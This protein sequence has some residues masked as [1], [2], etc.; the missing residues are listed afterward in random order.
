MKGK[1]P[2][3]LV[4]GLA[5]GSVVLISG[6]VFSGLAMSQDQML[7]RGSTNLPSAVFGRDLIAPSA[8]AP[9][10]SQ[11]ISEVDAQAS[12][13]SPPPAPVPSPSKGRSV[14][15]PS[16]ATQPQP[17]ATA[18]AFSLE[19]SGKARRQGKGSFVTYEAVLSNTGPGAISGVQFLAHVPAGTQWGPDRE[20]SG[21]GAAV[22][23]NYGSSTENACTSSSVPITGG[24]NDSFHA[25]AVT[26]PA[27]LASGSVTRLTFTVEV[28][29]GGLNE[30][31]NH[32]HAKSGG[33][34][35]S[36]ATSRTTLR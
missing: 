21:T 31:E 24:G 11:L 14:S 6:A 17:A 29:D 4:A 30:V 8:V 20:C 26:I 36:T 3:Y 16:A 2:R 23:I 19:L 7:V 15:P 10:T 9:V 13:P 25:V 33:T 18:V 1:E 5:F 12:P 35:S 34:T 22:V 28:V 32:A 27:E